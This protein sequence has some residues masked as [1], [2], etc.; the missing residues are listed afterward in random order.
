MR[1][2]DDDSGFSAGPVTPL[3]VAAVADIPRRSVFDVFDAS[4][5]YERVPVRVEEEIPAAGGERTPVIEAACRQ[6]GPGGWAVRVPGTSTP[7]RTL[8]PDRH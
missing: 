6:P 5:G 4:R 8:R 1:G 7:H 2:T 3:D